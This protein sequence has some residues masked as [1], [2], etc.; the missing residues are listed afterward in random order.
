LLL[1]LQ[2]SLRHATL[3]YCDNISAV[4]ISANPVQHLSVRKVVPTL[5]S[6]ERR[7]L[8]LNCRC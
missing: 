3:V 8:S 1:E 6:D 7:G 4:Y 2:S 5:T